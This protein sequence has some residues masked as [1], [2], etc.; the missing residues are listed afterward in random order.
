[1]NRDQLT[2]N[3][4]VWDKKKAVQMLKRCVTAFVFCSLLLLPVATWALDSG[5]DWRHLSPQERED[6]IRNYRRWQQLS[7]RDKEYLREEWNRWQSLPQDRRDKLRRRYNE[8][9]ESSPK[10]K[11]DRRERRDDR[12]SR[13]WRDRDNN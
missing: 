11:P 5:E 3:G 1:M 7:P 12:K 13:R 10:G 8:L 6:V 9:H 2:A 4:I